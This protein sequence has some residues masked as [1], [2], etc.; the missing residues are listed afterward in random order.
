M[1][2]ILRLLAFACGL[3]VALPTV[4]HDPE[5]E[6]SD[7]YRSLTVPGSG[8]SCCS[9]ARDCE[10]IDDYHASITVPGGYEALY[11]GSWVQV[12]PEKVLQRADNP[13]GHGVLCVVWNSGTPIA[14]CFVR[15]A[16][17]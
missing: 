9:P 13:T 3:A 1:K 2:L 14:R 17:G 7:W 6:F 5:D 16:E 11:H 8:I 12:P 10:P 4:A 15:G